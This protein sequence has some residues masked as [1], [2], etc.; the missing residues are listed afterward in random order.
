MEKQQW[1]T[2]DE[3]AKYLRISRRTVY[4]LVKDGRLPVYTVGAERHRR[5][6]R[7]DLD[8]ALRPAGTA[9]DTPS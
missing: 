6:R 1:F 5:F 4:K 9:P 8:A 3:A 7:E 2:V